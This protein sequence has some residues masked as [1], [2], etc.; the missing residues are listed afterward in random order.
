[1]APQNATDDGRTDTKRFTDD[2][3]GDEL[4]EGDRIAPA[5]IPH[6]PNI[7]VG[8]PVAA[9]MA[10]RFDE[11]DDRT[12]EVRTIISRE[13]RPWGDVQNALVYDPDA[14]LLIR[15]SGH[16]GSAAMNQKE[17]DWKVRDIGEKMV[18]NDMWDGDLRDVADEESYVKQWVEVLSQDLAHDHARDDIQSFGGDKMTLCDHQGREATVQYH[19]EATD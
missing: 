4:I 10:G 13:R 14:D 17:R 6:S 3:S 16:T 15:L 5:L 11:D 7:D 9:H 1:M 19:L 18:V 8:E 12:F 2:V